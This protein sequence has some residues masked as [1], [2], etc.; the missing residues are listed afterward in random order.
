MLA[1]DTPE[2][3]IPVRALNAF[4]FEGRPM[5]SRKSPAHNPFMKVV[6]GLFGTGVSPFQACKCYLIVL[7]YIMH[8]NDTRGLHRVGT[9][10]YMRAGARNRQT[11]GSIHWESQLFFMSED[12]ICITSG[13]SKFRGCRYQTYKQSTLCPALH[14]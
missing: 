3:T 7:F 4:H 2:S 10:L 1:G 9:D 14:L 11:F 13:M 6:H 5:R 8:A 12:Q